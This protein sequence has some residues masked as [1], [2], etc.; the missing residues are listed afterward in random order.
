MRRAVLVA[1]AAAVSSGAATALYFGT[2]GVTPFPMVVHA[3][4]DRTAT[5]DATTDATTTTTTAPQ[6]PSL[7]DQTDTARTT[8]LG[9]VTYGHGKLAYFFPG[10]AEDKRKQLALD[11]E[12]Y[13]STT[14]APSADA[15]T[16]LLSCFVQDK[17][18]P[19]LDAT[20]CLGGNTFSLQRR[21]KNTY[22]LEL[23]EER[24]P[25]LEHNLR[26]LGARG[27]NVVHGD[28]LD[29]VRVPVD[30]GGKPK[31]ATTAADN[32]GKNSGSEARNWVV[33]R[34]T[35][36]EL[37]RW[38]AAVVADPPWEGIDYDK[39][40][41]KRLRLSTVDLADWVVYAS[42]VS[43]V[44][45]CKVPYNY[46]F[47]AFLN[48]LRASALHSEA[49]ARP[50]LL[51]H[52]KL[53]KFDILVVT[54]NYAGHY[55]GTNTSSN[56][57]GDGQSSRHNYHQHHR[58]LQEERLGPHFIAPRTPTHADLAKFEGRFVGVTTY[59]LQWQGKQLFEDVNKRPARYREPTNIE[60]HIEATH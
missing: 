43:P 45:M 18:S 51:V 38:F 49:G 35:T 9:N 23:E 6:T 32:N 41:P 52:A 22:A 17:A 12:A 31:G 25:L 21:F 3:K 20:A 60:A 58:S 2:G 28:A 55:A 34:R 59:E 39:A 11:T 4:E 33:R 8:R 50:S 57:D 40:G 15:M 46:D 36:R 42:A 7:A 53:P 47:Q 10:V 37:P 24:I 16:E 19:V 27:V 30:N 1:A 13:Y 44:V 5:T 54:F 26:V 56:N 29:V 14:D 48:K